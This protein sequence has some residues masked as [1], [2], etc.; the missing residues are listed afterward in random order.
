MDEKAKEEW[1]KFYSLFIAVVLVF[2]ATW[3]PLQTIS[4]L[5]SGNSLAA[6]DLVNFMGYGFALTIMYTY[7]YTGL[8]ND[9]KRG[10]S[11]AK[12]ETK[13]SSRRA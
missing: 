7:T 8:Y 13:E 1:M 4:R 6:G 11:N 9:C 3:L 5:A 10:E 2:L 12:R